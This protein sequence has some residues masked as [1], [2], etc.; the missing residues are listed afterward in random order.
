ML[1]FENAGEFGRFLEVEGFESNLFCFFS[2]SF[3]HLSLRHSL[4]VCPGFLQYW[5]FFECELEM[6]ENLE[7]ESFLPEV[8]E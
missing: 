6:A 7:L 5:Q 3:F 2:C 4:R 8:R 1:I